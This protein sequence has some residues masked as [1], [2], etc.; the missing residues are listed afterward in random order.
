MKKL[1]WLLIAVVGAVSLATIAT[2]RGETINSFWLVAAAI[3]TYLVA[4]R[5]YGAFIAARVMA[6]DDRR[7]TPA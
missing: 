3:C 7:A 5:F 4:Y 2:S 6:L 1:L